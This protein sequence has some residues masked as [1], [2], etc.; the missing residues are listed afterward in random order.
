MIGASGH[1]EQDE[2]ALYAMDLLSPVEMKE[3]A[4]HLAGCAEC[5][6][7]LA[8]V[9]GDLALYAYSVE[10][11]SPPAL[12]R[13]RLMKQVA[14]EKRVAPSLRDSA[15]RAAMQVPVQQVPA[16][17]NNQAPLNQPQ[18]VPTQQAGPQLSHADDSAVL[19]F[20]NSGYSDEGE[21]DGPPRKSVVAKV[22]PWLGWAIAAG[23]AVTAGDFYHDRELARAA[24]NSQTTQ[25]AQMAADAAASRQ[26]METL[27]DSSAM[28]VTMR[29]QD[30]KPAAQGRVTYVP[31]KG[32]LVMIASNLDPLEQYK[33][34]ELWVIP[35]D[36]RD[37]VAAGSFKPDAQGNANVILPELPKGIDAKAFAVTI[38]DE[39]SPK[40]T[41]TMP[42]VLAGN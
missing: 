15:L 2:M 1:I 31:E 34:Y 23:L 27:T 16:P 11:H 30:S 4:A 41:P 28:R 29:Q 7:E 8:T 37:P 32:A 39:S 5:S 25:M 40:T 42:T 20:R 19:M 22:A 6:R 17:L 3:A 33:V 10:R 13:E 38:E 14:R 18:A 21:M 35:A 24:V 26:L 12:A 9:R 36:G